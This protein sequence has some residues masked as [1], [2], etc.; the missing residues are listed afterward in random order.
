[1]KKRIFSILMVVVMTIALV[2]CGTAQ[3]S[4]DSEAVETVKEVVESADAENSEAVSETEQA[5][6]APVSL[7]ADNVAIDGEFGD[8]TGITVEKLDVAEC[9][10]FASYITDKTTAQAVYD[11]GLTDADKNAV[12]PDG[13]VNVTITVPDEMI[14]AEGDNYLVYF[15]NA[16]AFSQV[17]VVSVTSDTVTFETEHFSVYAVVKF[18]SNVMSETDFVRNSEEIAE[19]ASTPETSTEENSEAVFESDSEAV[20]E[21]EFTFTEVSKTLYAIQSVNVRSGP[22]TD[23]NKIGGLTTNQEIQ[24]I[25]RCNETG[26]YKFIWT[27]GSEAYVSDKYLSDSKVEKPATSEGAASNTGS[28]STECPYPMYQVIDDGGDSVYYYCTENDINWTIYDQC[29]EIIANRHG[30]SLYQNGGDCGKGGGLGPVK[31]NYTYN[32]QIV[33]RQRPCAFIS[34]PGAGPAGATE[35]FQCP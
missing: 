22:S 30:H 21:P 35:V 33:Y 20:V 23:F 2:A 19:T 18:D 17:E 11:I 8:A 9:E 3:S 7:V 13:T 15:I 5:T 4:P 28:T 25:S 27:D 6:E 26:W 10:A 29:A 14:G 24:V 12:Q 1:M 31:T 16:D 32:G 34:Q